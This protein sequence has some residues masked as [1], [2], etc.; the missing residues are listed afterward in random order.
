MSSS[1]ASARRAVSPFSRALSPRS[2]P[3]PPKQSHWCAHQGGSPPAVSATDLSVVLAPPHPRGTG[4]PL[5]GRLRGADQRPHPAAVGHRAH[6][7]QRR[8][9]RR[10]L[11]PLRHQLPHQAKVRCPGDHPHV[12]LAPTPTDAPC[13]CRY[14][15]KNQELTDKIAEGIGLHMKGMSALDPLTGQSNSLFQCVTGRLSRLGR[16]GGRRHRSHWDTRVQVHPGEGGRG[17]AAVV[18]PGPLLH[19]PAGPLQRAGQER[20]SRLCSQ[21]VAATEGTGAQGSA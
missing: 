1:R 13:V 11:H 3:S 5:G 6:L 12:P 7:H 9:L 18:G 2:Y 20:R 15:I 8:V 10:P 14:P 19:V 4:C 21:C 17:D 16:G